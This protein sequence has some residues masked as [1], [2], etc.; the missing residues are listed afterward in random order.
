MGET[1]CGKTSLIKFF[2]QVILNDTLVIFDIHA[3]VN[4]GMIAEKV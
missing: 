2:S 4:Y 3:G 1:G